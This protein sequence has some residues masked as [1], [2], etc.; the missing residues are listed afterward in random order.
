MLLLFK[1]L[2]YVDRTKGFHWDIYIHAYDQIH[3]LCYFSYL[4]LQSI[5][6]QWFSLFCF[7][8][9]V[10]STSII[11]TSSY[12]P[13]HWFPLPNNLHYFISSRFHTRKR[14]C[15]IGLFQWG[16]FHLV[17]WSLIQSMYLHNFIL[18][19]GWIILNCVHTPH[20]LFSVILDEHLDGFHNLAVLNN[21]LHMG[22]CR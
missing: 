4:S 21:D 15:D 10:W 22:V 12:L 17:S 18:L 19:Y 11:L 20:F 13:T 2:T 6:K 14:L 5:L 9:C 3:L 8:S 7:H 16:L 1:K